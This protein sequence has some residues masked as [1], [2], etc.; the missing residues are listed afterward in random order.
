LP[1]DVPP[2]ALSFFA[3]AATALGSGAIVA[4]NNAGFGAFFATFSLGCFRL[5]CLSDNLLAFI[6]VH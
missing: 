5:S 6:S 2:E 1:P 4:A 3:S